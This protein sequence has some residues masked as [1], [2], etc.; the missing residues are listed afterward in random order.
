MPQ[1]CQTKYLPF[2]TVIILPNGTK[3]RIA[4]DN[5]GGCHTCAAN[6][7]ADLPKGNN[8]LCRVI[9]CGHAAVNWNDVTDE[10]V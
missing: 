8:A 4:P 1:V 7:R 2:G 5:Q 6:N 10:D 9:P 3:L